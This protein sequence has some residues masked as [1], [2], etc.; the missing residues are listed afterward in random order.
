[1]NPQTFVSDKSSDGSQAQKAQT[2][3]AA[4]ALVRLFSSGL[5][6]RRSTPSAV[7]AG[8]LAAVLWLATLASVLLISA[9]PSFAAPITIEVTGTLGTATSI[10]NNGAGIF[11]YFPA[12]LSTGAPFTYRLT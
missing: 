10:S 4:R 6:R 9:R 3:S 12:L 5:D 8:A 7:L 1:M 2:T 11:S